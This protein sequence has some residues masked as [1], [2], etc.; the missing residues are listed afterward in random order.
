MRPRQSIAYSRRRRCQARRTAKRLP[1]W[2]RRGRRFPARMRSISTTHARRP[3]VPRAH[4]S[5]HPPHTCRS[6]PSPVKSHRATSAMLLASSRSTQSVGGG[7]CCYAMGSTTTASSRSRARR[8]AQRRPFRSVR[9]ARKPLSTRS[10]TDHCADR[11]ARQRV[12]AR[13]RAHETGW[14]RL[15]RRAQ[16]FG[17]RP[18]GRRDPWHCGSR[19]AHVRTARVAYRPCRAR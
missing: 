11:D 1:S 6:H 9:E 18:A 10:W 7:H 14:L 3:R 19:A 12:S 8:A 5:G 16:S 13:W 15:A 2:M 17:H 4:A